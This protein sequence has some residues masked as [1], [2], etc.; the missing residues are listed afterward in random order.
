M[1]K[2]AVVGIALCLAPTISSAFCFEE[3]GEMYKIS[4]DLLWAI[5]KGESNFNPTVINYNKNGSYDFGVMQINSSWAK[6]LGEN[7]WNSL[8]DPCVNVKV[9][10]R[11]LADCI[12]NHGYTWKAV[13]CYNARSPEKQIIYAN[14]IYAILKKNNLV[15]NNQQ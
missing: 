12:K 10:A 7:L 5:A 13:G 3:A 15:S 14:K 6:D 11:I 9:G 8:G 4:P 2:R 1:L